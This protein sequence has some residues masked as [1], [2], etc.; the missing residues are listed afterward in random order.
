MRTIASGALLDGA[1]HVNEGALHRHVECA[2]GRLQDDRCACWRRNFVDG[3]TLGGKEPLR[4]RDLEW[5]AQRVGRPRDPDHDLFGGLGRRPAREH[6]RQH[7]TGCQAPVPMRHKMP[8]YHFGKKDKIFC[9]EGK[10]EAGL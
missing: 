6:G 4:D 5:P 8:R 10:S 2:C 7:Q 3:D 1:D 9:R